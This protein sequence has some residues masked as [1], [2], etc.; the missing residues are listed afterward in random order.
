MIPDQ[1]L[2]YENSQVPDTKYSDEKTPDTAPSALLP[3]DENF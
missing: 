3:P 1:K 2:P